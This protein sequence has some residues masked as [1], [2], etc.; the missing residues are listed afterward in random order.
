MPVSED[1]P[2][3]EQI[4]ACE[5][6]MDGLEAQADIWA[7]EINLVL[8]IKNIGQVSRKLTDRMPPDI[9]EG[10]INRQEAHIDALVRQAYLEG[11]DRGGESRK[12]YDEARLTAAL[13]DQVVVPRPR[14]FLDWA[15]TIFGPVALERRE[16]LTRFTEEALELAHAENMPIGLLEKLIERVWAGPQGYTPKEVGQAQACLE[17]FAESV[18][19]SADNEASREFARVQGIPKEE[20]TRRHQT[21]VTLGIADCT[22]PQPSEDN[23]PDTNGGER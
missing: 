17:T 21:K 23:G 14:A 3:P 8:V 2:T 5:R 9:R 4:A 6:A 11:F 22:P 7:D 16:R 19:L 1:N 18:G 10:F 20:W 13:S 12:A 15:A